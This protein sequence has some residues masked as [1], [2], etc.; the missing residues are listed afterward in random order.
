MKTVSPAWPLGTRIVVLAAL[1]VPV[2]NFPSAAL[3]RGAPKCR[4][5]VILVVVDDVGGAWLPPYAR[6]LEVAQ[7]EPETTAAFVKLNEKK[8][9]VDLQKNLEA[10]R[11]SMPFVDHLAKGGM[12]FDRAFSNASLCAPARCG[13]QTGI[14]QQRWGVFEN[15][16][17]EAIGIPIDTPLISAAFKAASYLTAAIGKWHT[18]RKEDALRQEAWKAMGESGEV[19]ESLPAKKNHALKNALEALAYESSAK[20]GEGPLDRG[21][22]YYFGYNRHGATYYESDLLWEGYTRLPKR[23]PGEFLTDL[24][25]DRVNS[26]AEAALKA[27]KPFFIYYAPMTIHGALLPPPE[28]YSKAFNTGIAQVDQYAGHLLAVDEGI[29]Q[30]YATLKKFHQDQNTLFI[31]TADNGAPAAIP[32][33][34]TPFRG[35]KG[36][37]WL[38]GFHVPL[39]MS[40]PGRI[41]PGICSDLI[42]TLDILPTATE[43]AGLP[44]PSKI[45]G[46][47]FVSFLSSKEKSG[48]R[49]SINV[50]GIHSTSW[51]NS[52]FGEKL[53]TDRSRCPLFGMTLEGDSV[54]LKITQTTPGLYKSYPDGK[55]GEEF[56]FDLKTDPMEMHNAF[57]EN[58]EKAQHLKKEFTS[59]VAQTKQPVNN[60]EDGFAELG[61]KVTR[62]ASSAAMGEQRAPASE[63]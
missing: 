39:I 35:G 14:S 33:Y 28:K 23:P 40:M 61:G 16:D 34:N 29:R 55:P 30:L 54:F 42:S 25:N 41:K 22:D 59:W 15:C 24:F 60:H 56:F 51:S 1:L 2:L 26:F 8:G 27:N 19:P 4:P 38:G 36:T 53:K 17:A 43:F 11:N 44:I 7:F 50:A 62:P 46:K 57:A 47:S 12:V 37:G 6:R 9:P 52:Y 10:A 49:Q 13:I 21:F 5:N 48:P 31:I 18:A 20:K 3:A 58:P 32:P 63:E 45:D